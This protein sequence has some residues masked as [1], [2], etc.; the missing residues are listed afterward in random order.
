[1]KTFEEILDTFMEVDEEE[2][3]NSLGIIFMKHERRRDL[4][5]MLKT[6]HDQAF[7]LCIREIDRRWNIVAA[8]EGFFDSG[9]WK[10]SIE[11]RE[12]IQKIKN[13]L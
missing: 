1:M 5:R 10:E 7:D 13:M 4:L 8:S 2:S 11:I 12:S 3:N 6:V 9:E